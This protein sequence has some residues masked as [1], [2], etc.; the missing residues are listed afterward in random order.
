[1]HMDIIRVS[2]CTWMSGSNFLCNYVEK[3][4]KN[5]VISPP[6]MHPIGSVDTPG[7]SAC[8]KQ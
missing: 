5:S 1:M 6:A 3:I 8:A 4:Q 2:K 7:P